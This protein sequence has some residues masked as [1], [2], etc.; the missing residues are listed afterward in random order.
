MLLS[1]LQARFPEDVPELH[2]RAAQW[3]RAQYAPAD[4]VYHLLATEAW[5]E[6]ALL[7]EEMALRE[8]EQYG[9]DSRLLRWL[10][11]LP[12]SIVQKHK[13]LLF[14]YLRL[15]YIALPRQKIERFISHIE[16]NLSS[17]PI[18]QQTGDEQGVLVEVQQ[19]RR[20]WEQGDPFMLPV[21]DGSTNDAKWELIN[22]LQLLKQTYSPHAASLEYQITELLHKAQS[23]GNLFVI[24]MAGGVLARRFLANGQLRRSEKIAR[25]V[26][27]QALV[28][29]GKLPETASIALAALSQICLEQNKLE[30]AQKYLAQALEV[31]PNPT[32]TNMLVQTAIQR[33]EIQIALGNFAEALSHIQSVRD[34]H[35]RR[36]SGLWTDQDLLAYQA[37]VYVRMGDVWGAE[38]ILNESAD[39][40]QHGLAQLVHAEILLAR[41]RAE[42][43]EALLSKILAQYPN[44]ILSVP[45][46]RPLVLLARA[47]FEQH[48]VNQALQVIKDAVRQ[49]AP[50]Q[51]FRPFLDGNISC[52][53]L[54]SLILQTES[55][56]NEA[57][58]FI[59][60]VLR[61]SK[62]NGLASQITQAEIDALSA[63]A[64]ISPREQ[65][66]LRLISIGCSNREIAGR[67]SVSEST[68]KTHVG[69]IYYK[70]DVNSRVQ[71]ITRAK[72]LRLV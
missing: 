41:K 54:L 29:R 1:Q 67:L 38:Q 10:Q 27:E 34:L 63:S 22:G 30:W 51:F 69:N 72:E 25:Q 19:I 9:E 7:M 57:Q 59:R 71:A 12:A 21:R 55:I 5:E 32:S 8:L 33:V 52:A 14:V 3:Y 65:E 58:T 39:F 28:Q 66:V 11:E 37:F 18:S 42:A 45:L 16:S 6:A 68:V 50:E 15:A 2:R 13:T 44:G 4:A 31:D 61:L 46:M 49:S 35:L 26:L 70:L 24:L 23:Q 64:S 43:A 48:K 40:G 36:P 53:P 47:L 62:Y 60:E 56:T 20:A 17:K